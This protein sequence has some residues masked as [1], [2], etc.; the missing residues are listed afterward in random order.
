MLDQVIVQGSRPASLCPDDDEVW[1]HSHRI[2][3]QS[4]DPSCSPTKHVLETMLV[5]YSFASLSELHRLI[6]REIG[7][8]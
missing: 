3:K 4:K 6:T 8:A 2:G 5:D 1:Q 7:V